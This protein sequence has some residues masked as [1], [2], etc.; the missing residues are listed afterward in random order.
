MCEEQLR[1]FGLFS[2]EWRRLRGGLIADFSSSQGVE[3]IVDLCS[4]VTEPEGTAWNCVRG[5]SRGVRKRMFSSGTSDRHGTGSPGQ[6]SGHQA[7][8]SSRNIWTMLSGMW[9]EFRV[10]LRG[11]RSWT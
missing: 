8:W 3:G 9:F 2:P 10:V 6:Q 1:S 4:L 5:G 11:T 7:C